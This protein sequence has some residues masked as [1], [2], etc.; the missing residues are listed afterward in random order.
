M[1]HLAIEDVPDYVDRAGGDEDSPHHGLPEHAQDYDWGGCADLLFQDTD[2]LLL[3]DA[4]LDGIEDP[5]GEINQALGL[6]DLQAKEWFEP[7]GNGTHRDPARG[8]RR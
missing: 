7:F 1:L 8:F 4:S 6:T 5:E 2:V 3:F